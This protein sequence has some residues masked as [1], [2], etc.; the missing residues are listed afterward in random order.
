MD[1]P[2]TDKVFLLCC[3]L[4]TENPLL[5]ARPGIPHLNGSRLE[6]DKENYQFYGKEKNRQ[7]GVVF[8]LLGSKA[9]LRPDGS[10]DTGRL[11]WEVIGH[12]TAVCSLF[13][14][15]CT[16]NFK[17]YYCV[18]ETG[19]N[20]FWHRKQDKP[21]LWSKLCVQG[22]CFQWVGYQRV[23]D[24]QPLHNWRYMYGVTF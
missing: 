20:R 4:D 6:W 7:R 16:G 13:V 23:Q 18:V 10:V 15:V 1:W 19:D 5:P 17:F 12:T 9:L 3:L 21:R 14:V 2:F 22:C 11:S 24:K 8:L